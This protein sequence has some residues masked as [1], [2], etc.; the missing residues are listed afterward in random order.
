MTKR[1]TVLHVIASFQIGGAERMAAS[2][3]S[4]LNRAH[5]KPL[6][7]GLGGSGPL[8]DM[9][10]ER[11]IACFVLNRRQGKDLSLPSKIHRLLNEQRVDV[12]Q[13]HQW[14]RRV[15]S[16][17]QSFTPSTRTTR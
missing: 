6:L 11:D 5:F 1:L 3:L 8:L 14:A 9:M 17:C 10:A 16:G 12:V 7:C 4:G 2:I 15:C 13:T